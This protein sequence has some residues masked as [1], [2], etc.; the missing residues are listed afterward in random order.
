MPS[1]RKRTDSGGV[2]E[3]VIVTLVVLLL[4]LATASV[5]I[6]SSLQA[7]HLQLKSALTDPNAMAFIITK[8]APVSDSKS[9]T[10]KLTAA[11]KC[12][13]DLGKWIHSFE[14]VAMSCACVATLIGSAYAIRALRRTHA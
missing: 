4:G 12:E 14:W 9:A 11:S 5:L 8:D 3:K 10:D 6:T 13:K 2:S 1:S 7:S